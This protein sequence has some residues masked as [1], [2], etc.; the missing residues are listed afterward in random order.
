M[1]IKRENII[2]N[3]TIIEKAITKN[4]IFHWHSR[5]ELCYIKKGTARFYINGSQIYGKKG[6][7]I[8]F[9]SG[10]IH[11]YALE[12]EEC[13]TYISTFNPTI[14]YKY[15]EKFP[16]L[17][18]HITAEELENYGIS[19][20]I[21][22]LFE[23]ML[24]E[25]KNRNKYYEIISQNKLIEIFTLLARHFEIEDSDYI[26]NAKKFQDFQKAL[27][28]ISNHYSEDISLSD[29]AEVLNY[30]ESNVSVMFSKFTGTNFKK[31]LDNIRISKAIE[32]IVSDDLSITEVSRRCGFNNIRT[33]NNVFKSVMGMAP[34]EI[35]NTHEH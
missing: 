29:L 35:K 27:E 26:S 8:F 30:S 21:L 1:E 17:K 3:W 16:A 12:N 11:Y 33:F 25:K 6:D 31:Y 15:F 22:F 5:D 2:P 28:F 18:Q 10:D 23:E 34:S 19:S 13:V 24:K 9:K 4:E 32:L 20:Y 14:I 7:I